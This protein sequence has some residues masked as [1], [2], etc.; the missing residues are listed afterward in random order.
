MNNQLS[1]ITPHLS[2]QEQPSESGE[3][4]LFYQVFFILAAI[5]AFIIFYNHEVIRALIMA[6]LFFA[7]FMPILLGKSNN[8][9]Q[10]R[11]KKNTLGSIAFNED[12]IHLQIGDLQHYID[13]SYTGQ[14]RIFLNHYHGEHVGTTY[15]DMKAR[16]DGTDNK[17]ELIEHDQKFVY[18]IF[19][20]NRKEYEL[21]Q[22]ISN[23]CFD[24]KL[25]VQEYTK[26]RR[27]YQGKKRSFKEIQ[28][29]NNR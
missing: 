15:T 1:I 19:L 26:G 5:I 7:F 13:P 12:N 28:Q 21:L 10:E 27:S 29:F 18:Y 16:E 4:T 8:N 2:D 20:Q 17:L 14:I 11:L 23:W 3:M 6:V 9:F 25:S 22:E 24:H